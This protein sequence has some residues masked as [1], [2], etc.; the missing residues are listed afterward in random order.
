MA[1][2]EANRKFREKNP[3]YH[4]DWSRANPE[5]ISEYNRRHAKPGESAKRGRAWR[6]KHPDRKREYELA[7]QRERR[8]SHL[9][10]RY[11]LTADDFDKLLASQ[12]GGCGACGNSKPRGQW[13]VDHCHATGTIRGILCVAC[14]TLLGKLE[15]NP[16]RV[17][18]L[19][20]Y[21]ER[22]T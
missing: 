5:K 12:G 19:Y 20:D 21:L 13:H 9:L 14:N 7:H 3:T 11:G 6:E 1:T 17:Q 10:K 2:A 15:K 18:S 8:E 16:R 22:T 4:R